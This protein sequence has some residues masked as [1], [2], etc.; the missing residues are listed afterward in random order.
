MA[1]QQ[2]L[3][4][5]LP[6]RRAFEREDFLVSPSNETA[7]AMVE[8]WD[9]WPNRQLVLSGP[10]GAGKTH[11]AHVWMEATG[12]ERVPAKSLQEGDVEALVSIGFIVVEDV[13]RNVSETTETAL[14]HF[15]NLARA[16]RACVLVTARSIPSSLPISLPDLASRMAGLTHVSIEP[17]DEALML[18]IIIKQFRDRHLIVAKPV[19]AFLS[20]RIERSAKA[21]AAVVDLLDRASRAEA[22]SITIPFVRRHIEF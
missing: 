2:I 9:A 5:S 22:Q 17:P 12:A 21:A 6:R 14:F 19:V 3:D 8:R 7:L 11:L 4:I 20:R 13:D 1:E 18:D 16:E 10:E 15:L